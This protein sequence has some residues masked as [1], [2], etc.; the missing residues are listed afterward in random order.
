MTPNP[1]TAT[2]RN[3]D[4]QKVFELAG[5]RM[6]EYLS[7][8][9]MRPQI[10][11]GVCGGRSIVGLLRAFFTLND[12]FAPIASKL[13]V[14]LVDE[15]LVPLD[16]PDS[17]FGLLKSEVFDSVCRAGLITEQQLHPFP[18]ERS[19][20]AA[21]AL[22]AESLEAH[23]GRFDLAV[24]GA[25]EDGHIASLFPGKSHDTSPAAPFLLVPDS[26]KPPPRRM[27]ASA[28]LVAKTGL[29]VVMFLGAGKKDAYRRFCDGA[30]SPE[31]CPA[32][33]ALRAETALVLTDLE[34]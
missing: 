32:K 29:S 6:S 12:L 34:G 33:K 23:G 5:A 10:V 18:V 24:F 27:S 22:Y 28:T 26:P 17:N 13:H 16:H 3:A 9:S 31:D 7:R 14:Y 4:Q 8:L 1:H 11:I 2:I 21:L 30:V 25:G 20:S 15:R 19:D